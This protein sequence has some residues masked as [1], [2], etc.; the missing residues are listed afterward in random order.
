MF[1]IEVKTAKNYLGSE[2]KPLPITPGMVADVEVITGKRTI[3]N[4]LMKPFN[5][6]FERALRER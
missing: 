1:E 3:L 5:R 2:T 6:G 4:Y